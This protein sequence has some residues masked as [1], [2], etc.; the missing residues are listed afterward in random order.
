MITRGRLN[1]SQR[2]RLNYLLDMLYTPQELANEIGITRRQIYR[3]YRHMDMPCTIDATGHVYINGKEFCQWYH[4][5][6]PK[7]KLGKNQAFCITCRQAV[8]II[9][10]ETLK[11]NGM[12]YTKSNCQNCNRVLIRFIKP[13]RTSG[14]NEDDFTL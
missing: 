12:V 13:Y 1:G 7:I 9:N 5:T 2:M 11:K 14:R 10:P 3:V 8:E 6:Y 4:V